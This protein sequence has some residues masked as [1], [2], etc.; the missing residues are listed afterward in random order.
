MRLSMHDEIYRTR[1][2]GMRICSAD[3]AD[4][5]Q[6]LSPKQ[7]ILKAQDTMT[8][9]LFIALWLLSGFSDA[10]APS[11]VVRSLP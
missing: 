11:F 5:L 4:I 10:V 2:N 7:I 8:I 6:Y 1:Y 3:T 9:R